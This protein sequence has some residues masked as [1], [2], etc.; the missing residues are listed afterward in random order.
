[1]ETPVYSLV[2]CL[3]VISVPLAGF[4]GS[5]GPLAVT[6]SSVQ[7]APASQFAAIAKQ[8][9][10]ALPNKVHPDYLDEFIRKY[11]DSAEARI[12]YG[13]RYQL[14]KRSQS[15]KAYHDFIG[16]YAHTTG[17]VLAMHQL[18][19][20]HRKS[21]AA[22]GYLDF[23]RRYPE[24]PHAYLALKH[25]ETLAFQRTHQVHS[26][27]AYDAFI[28]AFPDAPQRSTAGKLS[29]E[30]AVAQER[31][32][33]RQAEQKLKGHDLREFRRRRS[34]MLVTRFQQLLTQ[35]E[36]ASDAKDRAPV[37][38]VL[39]LASRQAEIVLQVYPGEEAAGDVR[40]EARYNRVVKELR[41][42]RMTIEKQNEALRTTL[43][44][45][46]AQL[47]QELA[48]GFNTLHRDNEIAREHFETIN[49]SLVKL[50]EDL[51]D[52]NGNIVKV[53]QAV[54]DVKGA[55]NKNTEALGVLHNDLETVCSGIV[56]MN[57]DMN[58]GFDRQVAATETLTQEVQT[59][60]STLHEDNEAQLRETEGLRG[61]VGKLT[62]VTKEG[63]DRQVAATEELTEHVDNGFDRQVAATEELTEHVDKGFDRQVAATEELTEHVD[64]GFD[65]QEAATK[66]LTEHVDKGF[67]RQHQDMVTL[68]NV[69]QEGFNQLHTDVQSLEETNKAGFNRL[70]DDNVRQEDLIREG[71]KQGT[72]AAGSGGGSSDKGFDL[73]EVV[74]G[75]IEK[76]LSGGK[77][78]A[79]DV[80]E[81]AFTLG[82]D[83]G[84]AIT[85]GPDKFVS[86]F[87]YGG[88]AAD[89]LAM[90]LDVTT[91]DD[92]SRNWKNLK[93][94][95]SDVGNF[96]DDSRFIPR[97]NEVGET[98]SGEVGEVLYLATV[99]KMARQNAD[100]PRARL[101][102]WQKKFMDAFL[103]DYRA[104]GG[105]KEVV[106]LAELQIVYD[107]HMTKELFGKG[108][109]RVRFWKHAS[110]G[111]TMG[112]TI[113]IIWPY[114]ER[115]H[116][117]LILLLHETIHVHQTVRH[118]GP[119]GFGNAYFRGL[120]KGGFAYRNNQLE[121]E[122]F[123]A[124]VRFCNW[125]KEPGKIRPAD[126]PVFKSI[127]QVFA[128]AN[129]QSYLADDGNPT[130]WTNMTLR[131]YVR[132]YPCD[133]HYGK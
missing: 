46:F 91:L 96:L 72:Q 65:R 95:L 64:K 56:K 57:E 105:V 122:A 123:R 59:G 101:T 133:D 4:C 49:T 90:A 40:S 106:N 47:R 38:N 6:S 75:T 11:P 108:E 112:K 33:L 81:G 37:Q 131:E 94:G 16:K 118:G 60:L 14:V 44:T 99:K 126:W 128:D 62:D 117:L 68:T 76:T 42:I 26:V 27:E 41:G 111:Q 55:I 80:V 20:L 107:A 97:G 115:S 19:G 132:D 12:A 58:T 15:A 10:D 29:R 50:H 5:T 92:P 109:D 73:F 79:A 129:G 22:A 125:L 17:G 87:E 51:V 39:R 86:K 88:R 113:Y 28:D 52:V 71:N 35:H 67:D 1:M 54:T 83:I 121:E 36:E 70:H 30:V 7:L 32:E 34:R 45:E 21:N 104:E 18:F 85:E 24:T 110:S 69:N 93:G 3:L 8:E 13:L 53:Y 82:N 102:A 25:V 120:K 127:K 48:E 98:L 103:R 78:H 9:W 100:K 124:G 119:D 63:F 43:R 130:P 114:E 61:D 89:R 23:M 31:A 2:R 84:V 66:E 74:T 77:E 116:Y